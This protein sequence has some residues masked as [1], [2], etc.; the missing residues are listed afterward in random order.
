MQRE[1]FDFLCKCIELAIKQGASTITIVDTVGF[2]VP[3]E[4]S[5]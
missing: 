5:N 2:T 3:K 1:D 4:I